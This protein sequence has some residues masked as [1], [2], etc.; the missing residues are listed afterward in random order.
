M[1]Q[2][3][4]QENTAKVDLLHLDPTDLDKGFCCGKHNSGQFCGRHKHRQER[5]EG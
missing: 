5:E 2:M 1:N 4:T 3:D